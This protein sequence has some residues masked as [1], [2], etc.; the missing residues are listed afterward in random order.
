MAYLFFG[1][2]LRA[3]SGTFKATANISPE[4]WQPPKQPLMTSTVTARRLTLMAALHTPL[5]R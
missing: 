3:I 2:A 1:K 4:N 5:L